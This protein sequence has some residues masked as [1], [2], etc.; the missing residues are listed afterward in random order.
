MLGSKRTDPDDRLIGLGSMSGYKVRKGEPDIRGWDVVTSDR[1][2][3]GNIHDLIVDPGS[4]KVRYID[5]ALDKN[6][7]ETKDKTHILLPIAGAALDDDDNRVYLE[8]IT[9]EQLLTIPPY[10]HRPITREYETAIRNFFSPGEKTVSVPGQEDFY[11]H[12]AYSDQRFW[13][14]RRSGRA[15]DEYLSRDEKLAAEERRQS[16]PLPPDDKRSR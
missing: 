4:M 10:D 2:K 1:K 8:Q 15:P 6:L 14:R 5:I 9:R 16:A 3:V 7:L 13:G 12:P 11:D